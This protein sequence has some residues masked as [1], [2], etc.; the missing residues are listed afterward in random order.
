MLSKFKMVFFKVQTKV[1]QRP[2]W[3]PLGVSFKISD[4]QPR[5]FH[6]GVAPGLTTTP[7]ISKKNTI[8][9]QINYIIYCDFYLLLYKPL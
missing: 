6:M 4:E 5:P 2:D 7:S 3:S 9:N 1:G 8:F